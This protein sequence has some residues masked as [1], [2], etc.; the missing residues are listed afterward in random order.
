[1]KTTKASLSPPLS[2]SFPFRFCFLSVT[3]KRQKEG[4][5]V[6]IGPGSGVTTIKHV[7]YV[8]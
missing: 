1:M 6:W 3:K 8:R 2:L 7:S 5:G 4:N